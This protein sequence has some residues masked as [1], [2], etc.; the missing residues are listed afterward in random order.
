VRRVRVP[1]PN[2]PQHCAADEGLSGGVAMLTGL[3]QLHLSASG[4]RR[5]GSAQAL[6][7]DKKSPMSG[8]F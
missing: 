6:S 1:S 7:F 5:L 4:D 3:F 2:I 8:G